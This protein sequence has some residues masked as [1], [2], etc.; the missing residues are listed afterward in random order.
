MPLLPPD[1]VT[2]PR[3]LEALDAAA[4]SP[5]TAVCAPAGFGKTTLLAEW[6]ANRPVAWVSLDAEDND[7]HR[8]WSAILCA[9]EKTVP[10]DS[11]VHAVAA[12]EGSS[13]A[14]FLAELVD[15][16][17]ALPAPVRLVLDDF[18]EIVAAA[19]LHD[20]TTLIRTPPA[21]LRLTLSA[22]SDPQLQL[23][24]LQVQGDLARVGADDLRFTTGETAQL[25]Q[26]TGVRC[27]EDDV[28]R[29][30]ERTAGW[31]AAVHWAA[32]SLRTVADVDAF[33]TQLDGDDRS[34]AGFLA[35]EVL[36]RLPEGAPELLRR[37]SVCDAVPAALARE[38][39]AREDAGAVLAELERHTFLVARVDDPSGSYRV[40][41]LLRSYLRADLDLRY[42]GL[43]GE[44][45]A[46][47]A[48][49]FAGEERIGEALEH[50]VA[51][52]DREGIVELLRAHAVGCL[53][54]GD[55]QAVRE[56]LAHLGEDLDPGLAAARALAAIQSG[57]PAEPSAEPLLARHHAL[58]EGRPPD[59]SGA[60]A[61]SE[62]G[63]WAELDRAWSSLYRGAWRDATTRVRDAVDTARRDG[64]DY[65]VLHGLA[66]L[67][68]AAG[69]G[70]SQDEARAACQ[71]AV[72]LAT[73]HGWPRSPWLAV[74]RLVLACDHLLRLDPAAA[75][76]E[77]RDAATP[78]GAFIGG[79]ALFDGAA[80]F[81]STVQVKNSAQV[82]NPPQ[83]GGEDR[84][85]G[86]ETM[87]HARHELGE[88]PAAPAALVAV[89]EHHAAVFL[90][91]ALHANEVLQWARDHLPHTR[92]LDLMQ[93]W[94]HLAADRPDDAAAALR[95]RRAALLPTTP[96]D[97]E[98]TGAALALRAGRRTEALRTL[99]HALGLAAGG[100]LVR[101]FALAD[102]AVRHLLVDHSGGFGRLDG[103]AAS[104]RDRLRRFDPAPV[105][106]R[107]TE[108]EQV[109]LQRL[110][111]QRSLDEIAA[112]L[113]VSVNT[114]KTHVRAIYV[115]LGVTN[116]RD[117]VLVAREHGLA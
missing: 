117:A 6:A 81:R 77:A 94:T 2:R 76:R 47:A 51:G 5:V 12:P 20:V 27:S 70:D 22:R 23:A 52:L 86:L 46:T 35:D 84:R 89:L 18:Q 48:R 53:L 83:F 8:F 71:E 57:E 79:A 36:A 25:L 65:L 115:K 67:A 11:R 68:V 40:Q 26:A 113:T 87:R 56:T 61:P 97:A 96:V 112:D 58:A 42:P 31:T 66:A 62:P 4:G 106:D 99:E 69:F 10:A 64:Q 92:E 41:P 44:L 63:T 45:H 74:C 38:L 114:V 90:G 107:L 105:D 72:E 7:P 80:Q 95:S 3:L 55:D 16:L 100:D 49:W 101:P 29:L 116:R 78:L 91:E 33:L 102:P 17:D 24:R 37:I 88:L 15:A 103:F 14:D 43:A 50:A 30:V 111:S 75:G 32:V 39:A 104:V 21:G 54:A 13:R 59:S 108:R 93:A 82:K 60:A 110:P 28:R 73:R 85:D 34:M 109:V 98:L 1:F 9:L 19:P